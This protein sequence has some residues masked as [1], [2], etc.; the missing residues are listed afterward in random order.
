MIVGCSMDCK[1][2]DIVLDCYP[3]IRACVDCK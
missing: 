3:I 1:T 2:K